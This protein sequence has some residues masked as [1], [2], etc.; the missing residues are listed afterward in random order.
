MRNREYDRQYSRET[1]K[2]YKAHGVCVGCRKRDAVKGRVR[3][4]ECAAK[5]RMRTRKYKVDPVKR[6]EYMREYMRAYRKAG[7]DVREYYEVD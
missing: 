2:W 5:A 4:P 6:R 1:Y 3:C 7:R